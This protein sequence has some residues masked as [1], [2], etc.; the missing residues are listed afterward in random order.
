MDENGHWIADETIFG[1]PLV[2]KRSANWNDYRHAV[3]DIEADMLAND[4]A[5]RA[6]QFTIQLQQQAMLQAVQQRQAQEIKQGLNLPGGGADLAMLKRMAAQGGK[7]GIPG[8][9]G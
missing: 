3:A 6:A 5:G 1:R 7:G 4:A 2:M 9:P 8:I